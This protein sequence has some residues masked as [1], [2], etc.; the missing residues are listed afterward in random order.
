MP[1]F[2][3]MSKTISQ[4][5]YLIKNV[6]FYVACCSFLGQV[7]KWNGSQ[8]LHH[9]FVRAVKSDSLYSRDG[10]TVDHAAR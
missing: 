7:P 9:R 1:Y 4:I 10:T 6:E 3:I 8:T 5:I 2:L